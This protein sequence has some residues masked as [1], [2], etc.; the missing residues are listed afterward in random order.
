MRLLFL[1]ELSVPPAVQH[2]GKVN[3]FRK[4]WLI[5]FLVPLLAGSRLA[6]QSTAP[7]R[8]D[9]DYAAALAA[10]NGFLHAWQTRDYEAG[11]LM[12]T[13][14]V[15]QHTSED[16][17]EALFSPSSSIQAFEIGRGRKLKAGRYSFPVALFEVAS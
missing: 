9:R 16:H 6:A 5:A 8:I 10:L 1:R 7:E 17:V 3:L 15:R 12:I 11:L 2:N 14:R 4:W 13:D